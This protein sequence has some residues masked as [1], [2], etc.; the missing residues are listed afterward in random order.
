VEE[1]G[2]L[3]DSN[4]GKQE[5]AAADGERNQHK[6]QKSNTGVDVM[7]CAARSRRVLLT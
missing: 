5:T 6:N 3:C 1:L 2:D 7:C 4:N